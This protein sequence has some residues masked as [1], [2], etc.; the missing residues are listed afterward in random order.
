MVKLKEFA[1]LR[2]DNIISMSNIDDLMLNVK[3]LGIKEVSL[4]REEMDIVVRFYLG[5]CG[6][7]DKDKPKVLKEGKVDKL[8][9]VK[10]Y[11]V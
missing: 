9:G 8:L 2:G 7:Y 4:S 3:R 11:V 1:Q 10:L 6:D 5:N